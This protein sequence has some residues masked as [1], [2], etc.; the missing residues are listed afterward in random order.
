MLVVEAVDGVGRVAGQPERRGQATGPLE[1]GVAE[2]D[3]AVD[4][5]CGHLAGD[6]GIIETVGVDDGAE[7]GENAAHRAEA[8]VAPIGHPD[9]L[10]QLAEATGEVHRRARRD[11]VGDRQAGFRGVRRVGHRVTVG[12]RGSPGHPNVGTFHYRGRC[13]S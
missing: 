3:D 6:L 7:A 2:R 13:F 8:R 9:D 1:L 12:R 11:V 5:D 4:P 10:A